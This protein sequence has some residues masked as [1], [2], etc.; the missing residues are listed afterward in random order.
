MSKSMSKWTHSEL[1]QALEIIPLSDKNRENLRQAF[2]LD[3]NI[4][5]EMLTSCKVLTVHIHLV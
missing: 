5:G 2:T 1:L 3:K 4:N